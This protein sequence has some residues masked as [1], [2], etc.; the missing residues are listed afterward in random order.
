MNGKKFVFYFIAFIVLTGVGISLWIKKGYDTRP[1]V[2]I[3]EPNK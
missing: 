2:K 3:E 1:E